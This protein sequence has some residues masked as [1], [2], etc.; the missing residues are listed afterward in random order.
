MNFF[1]RIAID[2]KS[3]EVKHKE[4][5]IIKPNNLLKINAENQHKTGV[6]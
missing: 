1:S 4:S 2:V 6:T 3:L 5:V